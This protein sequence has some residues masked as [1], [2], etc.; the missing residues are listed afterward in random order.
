MALADHTVMFGFSEWGLPV[1]YGLIMLTEHWWT[2]G[3]YFFIYVAGAVGRKSSLVTAIEDITAV[4]I[5]VARVMLQAVRGVIVG[6][7]H[8]IC[9]EML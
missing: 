2:M 6:M 5:L 3:T 1:T 9:R 8:F 4:A 7:F